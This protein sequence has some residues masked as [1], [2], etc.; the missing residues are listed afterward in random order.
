MPD[1]DTHWH[2]DLY[3]ILPFLKLFSKINW[4]SI[5]RTANATIEID[6]FWKFK[7]NRHLNWTELKTK[8]LE[9]FSHY[10]DLFWVNW[11]YKEIKLL[12]DDC[13]WF[14]HV[15]IFYS[16]KRKKLFPQN[17]HGLFFHWF[18]YVIHCIFCRLWARIT[19]N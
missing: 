11:R 18:S 14:E 2:M 7:Q 12:F 6:L 19:V 13:L 16:S 4:Q 1:F 8:I 3:N 9:L 5:L 15:I 17:L 10:F